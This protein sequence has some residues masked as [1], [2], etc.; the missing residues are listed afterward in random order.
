MAPEVREAYGHHR[1]R[2]HVKGLQPSVVTAVR[3]IYYNITTTSDSSFVAFVIGTI[4]LLGL[5]SQQLNLATQPRNYISGIDVNTA[6]RIIVG[7][8][9]VIWIGAIIYYKAAQIDEKYGAKMATST[10]PAAEG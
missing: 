6:G 3:K 2:L 7:L 8:F 1:R 10:V 9:L 5:L 4:E